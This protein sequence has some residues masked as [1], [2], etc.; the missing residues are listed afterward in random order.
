MRFAFSCQQERS[1]TAWMAAPGEH[2]W[3]QNKQQQSSFTD[4]HLCRKSQDLIFHS[5][6]TWWAL[7]PINISPALVASGILICTALADKAGKW[8][9]TC[10][11]R[12][13]SA[14]PS[15]LCFPPHP[16]ISQK[17][18]IRTLVLGFSRSKAGLEMVSVGQVV[19]QGTELA[20]NNRSEHKDNPLITVSWESLL[21]I[22]LLFC[23]NIT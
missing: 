12:C 17:L 2:P 18:Q 10:N 21:I 5:L 7:F 6:E 3:M 16:G 11:V 15:T 13:N 23:A 1:K 19:H 22:N 20:H 8:S 14:V 9:S 4:V